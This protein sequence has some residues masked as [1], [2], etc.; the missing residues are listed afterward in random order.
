MFGTG[1][2][3]GGGDRNDWTP[4]IITGRGDPEHVPQATT[5]I[6]R[7]DHYFRSTLVKFG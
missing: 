5:W 1:G 7:S 4:M 3:A 2:S 6:G